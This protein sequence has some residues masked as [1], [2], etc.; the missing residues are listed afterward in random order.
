[1]DVRLYPGKPGRGAGYLTIHAER[2]GKVALKTEHPEARKRVEVT[3][4]KK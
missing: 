2:S 4:G 3:N 1:V